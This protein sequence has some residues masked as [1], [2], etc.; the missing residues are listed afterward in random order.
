MKRGFT[1]IELLVV[2]AIIAILAAILFPVFAQAKAQAK[3]ASALSNSKQLDLA[4]I[5][6]ENDADDNFPLGTSWDAPATQPASDEL[7]FGGVVLGATCF[8]SWTWNTA[9]YVKNVGVLGDVSG[10]TNTDYFGLPMNVAN[11]FSPSFG[12]NYAF[13]SPINLGTPTISSVAA[14][15]ADA[16]AN[17][18]M[19][20]SKWIQADTATTN[21]VWF[22]GPIPGG[23]SQDAASESVECGS[24]A[25]NCF[26]DWGRGGAMN[27]TGVIDITTETEGAYTAGN[28]FRVAGQI[29]VGWV[30]GHA[31]RMGYGA[32][33]VGTNFNYNAA[34][35]SPGGNGDITVTHAS[36]YLWSLNKNCAD[37]VYGP[38]VTP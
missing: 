23:M 13:L 16:P 36:Q 17:T 35:G 33:S 18:V 6:Y 29:T 28:A 24:L 3:A 4:C 32:L 9:P 31:K 21:S 22:V 15:A 14:T 27:N 25:Q 2:I 26:T 19:I 20:A 1:L 37:F 38:C 7:C 10:P 30:D 12:F 8:N 34:N 11:L 5:M